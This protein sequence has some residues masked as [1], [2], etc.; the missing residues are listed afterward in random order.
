MKSVNVAMS[1]VKDDFRTEML[2]IST[3]CTIGPSA[4][5]LHMMRSRS[6]SPALDA[7]PQIESTTS[8][9]ATETAKELCTAAF[10]ARLGVKDPSAQLIRDISAAIPLSTESDRPLP[11]SSNHSMGSGLAD[12][13]PVVLG[14]TKEA[15]RQIGVHTRFTDD[16][17]DDDASRSSIVVVSD[18][19]VVS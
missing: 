1:N 2:E 9:T 3:R 14:V 7:A 6:P 15:P 19:V 16:D 10:L 13:D 12:H 8:T 17:A 11:P 18:S 4:D 5:F